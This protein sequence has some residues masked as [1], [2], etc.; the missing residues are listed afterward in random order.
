MG[1]NYNMGVCRKTCG[2]CKACAPD[3]VA[4]Y[5]ANRVAMGF[6]AFDPAELRL[7]GDGRGSN[8]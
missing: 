1:D 7:G 8:M 6:L 2:S 5:N 4:C 3:D